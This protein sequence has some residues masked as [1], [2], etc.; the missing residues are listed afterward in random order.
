MLKNKNQISSENK[1][2]TIKQKKSANGENHQILKFNIFYIV[3]S[4]QHQCIFQI[5]SF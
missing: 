1:T 2:E 4:S 5:Q 3:A